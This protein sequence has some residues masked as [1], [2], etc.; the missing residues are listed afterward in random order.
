M[1]RGLYNRTQLDPSF[2]PSLDD[3]RWPAV[4]AGFQAA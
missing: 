4:L 3:P 1:N 2:K